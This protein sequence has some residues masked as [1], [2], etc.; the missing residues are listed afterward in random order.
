MPFDA[1]F[2]KD[3]AHLCAKLSAWAYDDPA[4]EGFKK[5][6]DGVKLKFAGEVSEKS[7]E[8]SPFGKLKVD[9]QAFCADEA[10]RRFI[11]FR[12]S[13]PKFWDWVTDFR[14]ATRTVGGNDI[15]EGFHQ[16]VT[17]AA[18]QVKLD[19]WFAGAAG[20]KIIVSG[21]SLG[22]ALAAV[23]AVLRD[24]QIAACYTFGQPRIGRIPKLPSVPICR[25]VNQA[26][27]VPRVPVDF[28]KLLHDVSPTVPQIALNTAILS[29]A[30]KFWDSKAN[31]THIGTAYVVAQNGAL[32]KD[33]EAE[34]L[35]F[36]QAK[37]KASA[38]QLVHLF[39]NHQMPEYQGDLI[40]D[41]FKDRYVKA[42]GALT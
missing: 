27:I 37:I 1:P 38:A 8:G 7:G 42:I 30:L 25:V 3:E 36:L 15:H 21:H 40:S 9:T 18:T 10:T 20:K 5:N 29:G 39:L 2:T 41:H 34:Y 4:S 11:V 23:T 28:M 14:I 24:G 12:G 13:E 22:G 35:N 19:S 17:G 16:S 32:I 6:I 31:Y 26:D 33:G